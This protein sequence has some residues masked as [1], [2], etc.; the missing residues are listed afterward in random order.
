MREDLKEALMIGDR[1]TARTI[2]ETYL[3]EFPSIAEQKEKLRSLAAV[4][5]RNQPVRVG[6]ITGNERR[7]EFI[8]WARQNLSALDV[9]R[10]EAVDSTYRSTANAIGLMHLQGPREE[11]MMERNLS[12]ER[13]AKA[14][15][16]SKEEQEAFLQ[17]ALGPQRARRK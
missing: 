9:A 2:V 1:T 15:R 8:A 7:V 17:R 4:A 13:A 3:R 14:V 16:P 6:G 5:D 10:I 12:R 11:R